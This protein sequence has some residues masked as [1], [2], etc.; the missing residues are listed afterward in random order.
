VGLDIG[1]ETPEEIALAI[2]AEIQAAFAAR[3]GG[4]LRERTRPLHDWTAVA[5]RRSGD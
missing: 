4:S 1:A 2:V 5:S 3:G